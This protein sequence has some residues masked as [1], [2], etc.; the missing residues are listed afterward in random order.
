MINTLTSAV[1]GLV[2]GLFVVGI[3]AVIP[4]EKL[5]FGKKKAHEAEHEDDHEH[6]HAESPDDV[7]GPESGVEGSGSQPKESP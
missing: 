5:P 3:V 7:K 1:V 4:F 2:V 6:D